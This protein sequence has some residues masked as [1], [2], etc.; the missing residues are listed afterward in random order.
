MTKL[1]ISNL[2]IDIDSEIWTISQNFKHYEFDFE[3][4]DI[5]CIVIFDIDENMIYQDNNLVFRNASKS[6]YYSNNLIHIVNNKMNIPS[7]IT[8]SENW[9]ICQLYINPVYHNPSDE[10]NVDLVKDGLYSAL[11][12]ILILALAYRN[13]V[14]IHAASIDWQGKGVLFSAPSETGKS[15]HAHLWQEKYDVP[16]LDGDVTACRLSNCFPTVYGLPWCGASGEYMNASLPLGAI[17]FL[18]QD[19]TNSIIK[20]DIAEA[21]IRLYARCFIY[22]WD[23][24][25]VDQV[26]ETITKIVSAT[27]CYLLKCRPDFEAVEMVKKWLEKE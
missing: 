15:T 10:I 24:K 12:M 13:G 2:N 8:A 9:S 14:F 23:E 20:L 7:R 25:L 17:V 16:I 6:V 11:K 21:T 4:S 26:L 3:L 18:E 5:R 27:D 1:K 22:S 19:D